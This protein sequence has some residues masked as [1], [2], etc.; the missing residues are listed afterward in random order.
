MANLRITR[1]KAAANDTIYAE[2]T[3][4]LDLGITTAC[5]TIESAAEAIPNAQVLKVRINKNLLI[6]TCTPLT[7][8]APYRIYF[9]STDTIKFKSRN[10]SF[11]FDDGV[12]NAPLVLG[13]ADP[14]NPIKDFLVGYLNPTD[15]I[16]NIAPGTL[17]NT[18]LDSQADV[19]A[20]ALYDIRQAK[21]DNYLSYKVENEIKTRG[22]GPFDRLNEEGSYELISVSKNLPG[23]V[24]STALSFSGMPSFPITLKTIKI[25]NEKLVIGSGPGTFDKLT[26]TVNKKPVTKL[27]AISV[28][29]QSGGTAQYSVSQYGYQI[30]NFRYDQDFASNYLLLE[31]NQFSLN[32]IAVENGWVSPKSGDTVYV[33]YEY[34]DLGR[35]VATD[36]VTVSQINTATRESTPPILTNFS[37]SHA[38]VVTQTDTIAT[39]G[40]VQFLDPNANPPFSSK[41]PAFLREIKFDLNNLPGQNG[42]YSINYQTGQVYCFGSSAN[43]GTGDFPPAVS[44][45]YRKSFIS[46]LDYTYDEDF[47]E[48]VGNPL[49]SIIG[50]FVKI[51]FDYE[52]FLV[53]GV[54]FV[55]Q[56]HT[57]VLDERIENNLIA[58]NCFTVQKNPVTAVF[59]IY[60]ETSGE[61]YTLDRFS[62]NR[63]YFNYR[64]PPKI[65]STKEKISFTSIFNESLIL[66]KELINS[67]SVRIFKFLLQNNNIASASEDAIGSSFNSTVIVSRTDLFKTELYYD[68]STS[69][70][71]TN[72]DRLQVNQYQVDYQ[73]GIV[74]LAVSSNQNLDVGTVSYKTGT[75]FPVNSHVTA[76]NNLY[77]SLTPTSTVVANVDYVSFANGEIIPFSLNA[78]NERF[79]NEDS[80]FPY[81]VSADTITVSANIKDLRGV[82]DLF[83]LNNNKTP[84]DFSVG[85]EVSATKI[86]LDT[87][88]V[89]KTETLLVA[90]GNTINVPF[91][92]SG[93]EISSVTSVINSLTGVEY[94]STSGSYSNY[95]ITL[96]SSV[97]QNTKVSVV[98][99]LKLNGAA[100]PVVDYS[101]GDFIVDYQYLADEIL[102]SYEYGDNCL[103]FRESTALSTG[104]QYYV[105]YKVGALRGALLENFGTIV[106]IPILQNF[107]TT[108]SRERYRDA[109]KGALQSFPKGPTIP[110][111]KEIVRSI[112]HVE[113]EL[114]ESIYDVWSLGNSYLSPEKITYAGVP[115]LVAGKYNS[116]LLTTDAG[117]TVKFPASSLLKLEE[118][119]LECWVSPEWDGI[120]ND[121]TLTMTL[122]K[123]GYGI[124][125]SEVWIGADS[126][127]PEI[128]DGSFTVNKNDIKSPIGLPSSVY[129]DTGFFI[130]YDDVKKCWKFYARNTT[131][132]NKYSGTIESSGEVYDVRFLPGLGE[133]NDVLRST[134]N[135]ITFEFNL[136]GQDALSPDGYN[137]GYS[138]ADGYSPGDGYKAGFSFDGIQFMADDLHYLFDFGKTDTANRFSL[139]KDGKGYL[140]FLVFDNGS[141]KPD[142]RSSYRVSSDISG[143]KAGEKHHIALS[144]RINS[145]DHRDELHMFLDGQEVPNIMA[146][147]GRPISANTDR[148][149]TIK[150]EFLTSPVVKNAIVGNDLATTV[151]S[152]IVTSS[153][154]NF[155]EAGL[156]PGDSFTVLE[157]GF[158]T[159]TVLSVSGTAVVLDANMPTT[160]SDARFSANQYSTIVDTEIDLYRN[161]M[162]SVIRNGEE[163]ELPGMRAEIPSYSFSKNSLN[164]NVLT[165][166]GNVKTGDKVAIRTLGKNHRRYRERYYVWGN[167]TSVIKTQLPSPIN[168]DE[169]KITAVLLPYTVATPSNSTVSSGNF[170]YTTYPTQPTN[171]AEGRT[172]SVRL[173]GGNVKF[174]TPVTVQINGTTNTGATTEVV[175]FTSTGTKSTVLKF[176]T[177]SSS[178]VTVKPVTTSRSSVGVEIKEAYPVTYPDGN[179]S[180]PIIRFSYKTQAG[181]KLIGTSGSAVV[182]DPSAIFVQSNVGQKFII[183]TPLSAAGTYTI[184]AVN[185]GTSITLNSVM[186]ASFTGGTYDV[187]N[188]SL[189]RSGFQ[190]GFFTLEKA[191]SISAGYQIPQGYYEFDYASHLSIRFDPVND[192]YAYVGT[193]FNGNNPSKAVID[194]LVV[195]KNQLSDV[196]IG[197]AGTDRSVTTDMLSLRA[198]KADSSTLLLMHFDSLP[199]IN[200]ADLW[201]NLQKTYL[202]SSRSVNSEFGQSLLITDTPL[203]IDNAGL[204]STNK[205]GTIEF[206]VS[207]RYDTYNDP[208]LRY[209]FDATSGVTEEATSITSGV[210]KLSSRASSILSVRLITDRDNLGVNYFGLLESDGKTIRLSKSLPGQRTL[211]KINYIPVGTFGDRISIFKDESGFVVFKV[212]AGGA[213]FE[214]RQPI[215]WQRDTWHRIFASYKFNSTNNLDEIK[216]FVDGEQRGAATFGSGLLFGDGTM[217]GQGTYDPAG[218][219]VGDM[220]FIDQINQ[221]YIGSDYL[222]TNSAQ[223]RLDNLRLSN[224]ARSPFLVSGQQKDI[225]YS[226]NLGITLPVVEDLYTTYLLNFESLLNKVDDFAILIDEVSGIF[227]FTLNIL[228]SFGI[229]LDSES[230]R[231]ILEALIRTLKPATSKVTINYVSPS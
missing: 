76:V 197:E 94:W 7:P 55:P 113:P 64:T 79:L 210:V 170:I 46:G 112:T 4:N 185:S 175:T 119:T 157:T 231:R 132:S 217:F 142:Y 227:K 33:T 67:N 135:K 61:I 91:I 203:E 12:T 75:I 230:I 201:V 124:S 40:G 140:N 187:F 9:R 188:I 167:T 216:L 85:A 177:I 5:V 14:A 60:N 30:K 58:L 27:T 50:A 191:G 118:G 77:Y 110:A 97:P 41:H 224:K 117:S 174:T 21:N 141:G 72:I 102:V 198:L 63:V 205:E 223:A 139:F 86:I 57:E 52:T 47:Q 26:L 120:D 121:A 155:T 44:Y 147:G 101:R 229:L 160:L 166:L 34:Q 207:P 158:S 161:I 128:T 84:T 137:D 2:F 136:D 206:W 11:I 179:N 92:T 19:L 186:P 24:Q 48:L 134:N 68:N 53:P 15:N 126:H 17:V 43:D 107:D 39:T 172:L 145:E 163:I 111:M 159:Y 156:V 70:V 78:S 16:Y 114:K 83:D 3:E 181:S 95:K 65:L 62:N 215:F 29:Y 25:A 182:T 32:E 178:V 146:Y 164:Q 192:L 226:S 71:N 153:S 99:S 51:S 81:I 115:Q 109:L 168:L 10:G 211:L 103:D 184:S 130:Y 28:V 13:P 143:W 180:Y 123:D 54:D 45:L 189:G 108:I 221:F 218:I 144:W 87:T 228:D 106:D 183:K 49:R 131:A 204:F 37:L 100:T 162:V 165:I 194:E 196:R 66:N 59:R 98:Y 35:R 195:L 220:N 190:N 8:F 154:I 73:N 127:H 209:Y 20:R 152:N 42:D 96:S 169:A 129:T 193:D 23:N 200:S 202:Q 90:A 212:Q 93:A 6:V 176:K 199:L 225:N 88:A 1:I 138:V 31:E 219:A 18:V 38:P 125:S 150:P 133:I 74:Y 80:N 151:G 36:S 148:F 69:S 208:N 222:K 89:V 56:I 171:S 122:K 149:R 214:T 82:Y 213:E 173:T 104:Q 116:G 22:A 105:T